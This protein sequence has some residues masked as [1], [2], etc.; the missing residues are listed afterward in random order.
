MT[1]I[2]LIGYMGAGKTT[3]GKALAH[4]LNLSFVDLDWYTEERYHKSINALFNELGESKF[5]ELEKKMLHE[6]S[7]FEEVIISTGGGTPCFFDNMEFM[8]SNGDTVYLNVSQEVLFLRLQLA[9]ASRPLLR[10]KSDQELRA[11]IAEALN[12]REPCY[13]QARF[14]VNADELD[15]LKQISSAV[16]HLQKILGF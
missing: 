3:L 1:R 13:K 6:V 7:E 16:K 15:D 5:R 2:F 9:K 10:D 12:K 14:I 4:E 11:F 8:N